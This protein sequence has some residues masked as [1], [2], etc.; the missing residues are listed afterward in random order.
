M[1]DYVK[2]MRGICARS[3]AHARMGK[4]TPAAIGG[5]IMA[6]F[7]ALHYWIEGRNG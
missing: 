6:Y 3:M 7:M 1:P 2:R 4:V 5:D